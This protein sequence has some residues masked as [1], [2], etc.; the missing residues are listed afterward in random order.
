MSDFKQTHTN[1]AERRFLGSMLK[2]L[3]PSIRVSIIEWA[4]TYRILTNEESHHIGKF[5]CNRIPAL[6]YVYDCLHN[7][8]IYTI[9]GR[10]YI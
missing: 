2:L 4:E 1:I 5:D 7:R 10:L 9:V 8:F 6:E 3:R